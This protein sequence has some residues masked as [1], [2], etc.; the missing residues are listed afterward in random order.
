[1]SKSREVWEWVRSIAIAV[2]L[3]LLIRAFVFEVYEVEGGSMIPSLEDQERIVANK[4]VYHFGSPEQGDIIVFEFDQ[5]T[6]YIKRVI[7]VGGDTIEIYDGKVYC[8]GIKLEEP[9]LSDDM[10]IN[11]YGPVVVPEGHYFVM[12]DNRKDSRDS[13]DPLVGFVSL[14]RIKGKASLII[15]PLSSIR[16]VNKAAEK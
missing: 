9:Y 13:R 5:H 2:I 3:A 11:D 6:D 15:W 8:N 16:A 4:L 10:I 1:M 14:E 12:G 7:G